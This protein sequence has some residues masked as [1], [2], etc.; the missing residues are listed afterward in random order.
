MC[1]YTKQS[2]GFITKEDIVCYKIMF[3]KFFGACARF[4]EFRYWKHIKYKTNINFIKLNYINCIEEG[5]HSYQKLET[6]KHL[7]FKNCGLHIYECIIPKGSIVFKGD[8]IYKHTYD[9]K[10]VSVNDTMQYASNQI[11]IKKEIFE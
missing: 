11:I 5:F 10:S 9:Y 3:K 2:E 4:R 6:A 7:C 8:D 1:L